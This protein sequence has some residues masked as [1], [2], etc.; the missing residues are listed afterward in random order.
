MIIENYSFIDALFMTII[1]ISTVGY[2]TIG[3]LSELGI[4]FTIILIISSIIAVA[5]IVQNFSRY[6]SDG[7]I[8]TRLRIRKTKKMMRKIENHVIVCGY[9]QNGSHAAM[10]LIHGNQ[11]V[12]VLDRSQKIIDDAQLHDIDAIFIHGDATHEEFLLE[13]K[14][15]KAKAL[16]TSLKNDAD[17]LYVVLSARELNP[18]IKIVSK[19]VEISAERKLRRAGADHVI[20]P[21]SVGGIRMAKLV[22]EPEVIEFLEFIVAKSGISVNLVEIDCQDLKDSFIGKSISEL[23][24]RRKSGANIIGIKQSDGEYIFN[25]TS[26]EKIMKGVKLFV[27][28]TPKQVDY[29]KDIVEEH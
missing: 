17:N 11:K 25:P 10:E 23:D 8:L 5:L 20:L 6:I 26:D 22:F 19:A 13:A 18:D 27:L 21:D 28:G 12:V 7:N 2:S 16:I 3:K 29:F 4:I 9:G 1:T 24:I 15:E 14:V